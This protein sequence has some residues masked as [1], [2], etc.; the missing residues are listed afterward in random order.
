[1][2][3]RRLEDHGILEL[4]KHIPY[5]ILT[6]AVLH[7]ICLEFNDLDEDEVNAERTPAERIND[8]ANI[9]AMV[10]N[11]GNNINYNAAAEI[12]LH[13]AKMLSIYALWNQTNNG[14]NA[15]TLQQFT[16]VYGAA[17]Y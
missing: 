6:A 3:W 12:I 8:I 17:A 4:T 14:I 13:Q 15:P 5:F 1:M 16:N 11:A 9:Q 7:N 10:N 2:K